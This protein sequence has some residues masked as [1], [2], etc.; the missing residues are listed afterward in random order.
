MHA[1]CLDEILASRSDFVTAKECMTAWCL[2]QSAPV[3]QAEAKY[4]LVIFSHGIGGNRTA[5][6]AIICNL[7]SQVSTWHICY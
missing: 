3:A 1:S 2:L 7:V 4:P 6:S 5:Y